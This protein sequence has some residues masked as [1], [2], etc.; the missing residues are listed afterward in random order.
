MQDLQEKHG[1]RVADEALSFFITRTKGR[2]EVQPI[3]DDAF[4]ARADLRAKLAIWRDSVDE[5][6]G[7]TAEV[8]FRDNRLD[9]VVKKDLQAAVDTLV[10]P[11]P[12]DKAKSTKARIYGKKA[13]FEGMKPTGGSEQASYVEGIL[14]ELSQPEFGV[15]SVVA[16]K[17]ATHH[18]ALT[19]AETE[20]KVARTAE[21]VARGAL[22]ASTADARAFY[23]Q[24]YHRL[25]TLLPEEPDYVESCFLD[26][27]NL[28][29]DQSAEARKRVLMDV[30][31]ARLGPVPR[32]VQAAVSGTEDDETFGKLVAL[33][34]TKSAEEIAAAVLPPKKG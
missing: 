34:A 30:Y 31:R 29:D 4:K 33:F 22:D 11:L 7:G 14:G 24:A 16:D 25:M 1:P 17:V 6:R 9:R 3:R 23:N 18:T 2:T 21:G 15:L 20:R 13:P 19:T 12:P 8:K 26:L 32:E 27:R 28:T 10:L 5:S